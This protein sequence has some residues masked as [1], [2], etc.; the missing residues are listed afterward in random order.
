MLQQCGAR[1][2]VG[3]KAAAA[4]R[5][6]KYVKYRGNLKAP[7]SGVK[8][9]RSWRRRALSLRRSIDLASISPADRKLPQMEGRGG[10][11]GL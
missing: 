6:Y 4:A 1:H 2:R 5:A 7:G 11:R 10:A 9:A 8:L 3:A